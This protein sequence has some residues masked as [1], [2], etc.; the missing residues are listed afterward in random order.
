MTAQNDKYL[1]AARGLIEAI[2]K[3]DAEATDRFVDEMTKL[4]ETE[5]FKEVGM[6]T[7]QLHESLN[8][9]RLDSRLSDI[10]S[11]DIPDARER[12]NYVIAKT[13]DAAHR[14]LNAIEDSI[15][16]MDSLVGTAASV[17]AEWTRFRNRDLSVDEFR[18]LSKDIDSFLDTIEELGGKVQGNLTE[19]LMAQDFQ[20]LT[21]Q[22]IRRV[23][24]LVQEV[25][26]NLVKLIRISGSKQGEEKAEAA[27]TN[28]KI[29]A[30][31]P[32]IPNTADTQNATV[33]N[34]DE[35][36]DLLSSLGF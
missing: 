20:D 15:T 9:F 22:V 33:S 27:D 28:D 8:S 14:T 18:K 32:T 1:Q 13:E 19:A 24:S 2:E 12:L 30:E 34:Q 5:L 10:A 29:K 3:E 35:V 31:G 6:L 7:R 25:E 26:D 21:G 11:Q 16:R 4:R 17:K 23:I 36:D